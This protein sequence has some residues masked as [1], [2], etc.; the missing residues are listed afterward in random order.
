[1]SS[2]GEVVAATLVRQIPTCMTLL[3]LIRQ[4]TE[5]DVHQWRRHRGVPPMLSPLVSKLYPFPIHSPPLYLIIGTALIQ[6]TH[7]QLVKNSFCTQKSIINQYV[8]VHL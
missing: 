3:A 5:T 4:S 7:S 6:F 1:M 2:G 8:Q